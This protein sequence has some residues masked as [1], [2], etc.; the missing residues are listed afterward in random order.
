MCAACGKAIGGNCCY[1]AQCRDLF[2]A[3]L[4]DLIDRWGFRVVEKPTA[5]RLI[6]KETSEC[7]TMA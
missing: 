4:G 5:Q 1:C 6:E 2:D 3:F 7:L